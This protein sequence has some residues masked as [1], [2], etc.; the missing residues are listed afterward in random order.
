LD[1]SR[2]IFDEVRLVSGGKPCT[3]KYVD[4]QVVERDYFA[5]LN[6]PFVSGGP[7]ARASTGGDAGSLPGVVNETFAR[8]CAGGDSILG[9]ATDG[10]GRPSIEIVGV[11]KNVQYHGLKEK[12]GSVM[13]VPADRWPSATVPSLT[14]LVRSDQTM[15]LLAGFIHSEVRQLNPDIALGEITTMDAQIRELLGPER[16][17]AQATRFATILGLFLVAVGVY[18]SLNQRVSER[19]SEYAMRLAL[20]ARL[21]QLVWSCVRSL[22]MV[23]VA[24]AA[25]GYWVSLPLRGLTKGLLYGTIDDGAGT[26]IISL[27]AVFVVAA[28]AATIPL[29]RLRRFD[30]VTVLRRH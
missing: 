23:L 29:M 12:I 22:A 5:I 14:L 2:E 24:G 17:L 28:A 1:S 15:T 6:I 21:R 9:R 16:T 4:L 3:V 27:L 18:G 20:G 30:I 10:R 19:L 13:Y 11:V 26:T 8:R 7:P 25:V